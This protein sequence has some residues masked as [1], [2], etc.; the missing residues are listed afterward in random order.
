M[1]EIFK[2]ASGIHKLKTKNICEEALLFRVFEQASIMVKDE[3]VRADKQ[4]SK[5]GKNALFVF[6]DE[7]KELLLLLFSLCEYNLKLIFAKKSDSLNES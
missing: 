2:V 5:E 4:H 6:R 1:I 7:V 3:E